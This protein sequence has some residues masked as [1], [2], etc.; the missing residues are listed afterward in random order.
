MCVAVKGSV[1]GGHDFASGFLK[2]KRLFVLTARRTAR[3]CLV[4]TCSFW[5]CRHSII[6]HGTNLL[7]LFVVIYYPKD[8]LIHRHA[9]KKERVGISFT[10]TP[11]DDGQLIGLR[12]PESPAGSNRNGW[13]DVIGIT[14]RMTPECAIGLR[15]SGSLVNPGV[16]RVN[17][18]V[19]NWTPGFATVAKLHHQGTHCHKFRSVA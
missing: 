3:T 8:Y 19:Q 5:C 4:V 14:G 11:A 15:G 13:P 7:F 6:R 10:T 17:V 1:D 2:R 12:I 16:K 18:P 9:F